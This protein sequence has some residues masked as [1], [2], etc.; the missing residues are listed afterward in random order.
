MSNLKPNTDSTS[1][2]LIRAAAQKEILRQSQWAFNIYAAA[3]VLSLGVG[4]IGGCLFITGK[5]T[6]GTV[7]TAAGLTSSA[8]C[9]QLGKESQEKLKMLLTQN[10]D[11]S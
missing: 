2:E 4:V 10:Q 6:E 1:E 7:T 3:M 11:L 8:V 5:S 9:F